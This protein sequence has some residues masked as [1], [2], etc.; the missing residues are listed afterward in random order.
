MTAASAALQP[1]TAMLGVRF[2]MLLQYRAAALAGIF[3]QLV[4]GLVLIMIYEACY[5]STAAVQP[6]AF[7]Q[8]ASYV[9]LGQALLAM[10]PWNYD[11][12]LA[13]MVRSGA[14]AYELC[15]PIDLYGLW[16][17]RAVAFRTAP[18]VLRALPMVLIAA[19]GLP[20]VGLGEWRLAAPASLAAGAGFALA[21]VCAVALTAAIS[22]LVNISVLWTIQNDG[23]LIVV[24]SLVSLLSG[25]LVPLPLLPDWAQPVLRWLPFAGVVDLPFR[26]Y[27]GHI[28]AA[29][30]ALVLAKQ[31]GWTLALVALGRRLLER[32]LRRLVVQGG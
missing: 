22:T 19:I 15:R 4:F 31:I 29:G 13:A 23:V 14:V 5:R 17:A 8:V 24:T 30:I 6:M 10:L 26:I 9:W 11:R 32:G 7:A 1:Y 2:R 18:T 21:L 16:Y 12:E 3:T 27:S 25:L 28:A 20:L